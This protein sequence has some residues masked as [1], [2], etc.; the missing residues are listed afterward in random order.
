MTLPICPALY[1]RLG[2]P[3]VRVSEVMNVHRITVA[4]SKSEETRNFGDL[5]LPMVKRDKMKRK[6]A[7]LLA[8]F[9]TIRDDPEATK[10]GT[11][12]S[13]TVV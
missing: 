2:L 12:L 6:E 13:I 7:L 1:S 9:K 4:K 3:N 8:Y 5:L 11:I 10:S